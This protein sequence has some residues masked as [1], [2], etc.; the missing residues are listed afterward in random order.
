MYGS[1]VVSDYLNGKY[2]NYTGIDYSSEFVDI[3]GGKTTIRD[4]IR[5]RLAIILEK[6]R[7]KDILLLSH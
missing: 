5:G 3:S 1:E 6:H 7:K 4:Q 2:S